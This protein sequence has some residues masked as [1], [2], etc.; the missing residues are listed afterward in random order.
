MTKSPTR[1]FNGQCLCRA[2][3]FVIEADALGVYQCHCS[4]CRKITGSA[5]NSSCI[6]PESMFSWVQ[7]ERSISSYSHESGY[8]SDFCKNCG[9]PTPN[10]INGKPYYWVPAGALE[11]TQYMR[12][13]AHLCIES[14]AEWEISIGDGSKYAGVPNFEEIINVIID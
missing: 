1:K 6:I 14:K 10:K 2:I 7:G 5:A 13:K 3:Q 8:R 4:E 11:N 9:S 12:I